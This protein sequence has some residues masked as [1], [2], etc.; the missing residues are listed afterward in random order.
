MCN[1]ITT[2][3][4]KVITNP[5]HTPLPLVRASNELLLRSGS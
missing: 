4:G 5:L 1:R 2:M 3:R